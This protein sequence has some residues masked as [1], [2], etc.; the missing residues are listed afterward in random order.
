[1]YDNYARVA[2]VED[3][4]TVNLWVDLGYYQQAGTVDHPVPHRLDGIDAP[5]K[6]KPAERK[7]AKKFLVDLLPSGTK[8]L[9]K[10]VKDRSRRKY[11]EKEKYGRWLGTIWLLDADGNPVEPSVNTRM[12]EAGHAKPYSGGKR[13]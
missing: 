9:V 2:N 11:T 3:G 4:D 13:G 8:V 1:M 6:D 12:V 7:A 5:D 10:C